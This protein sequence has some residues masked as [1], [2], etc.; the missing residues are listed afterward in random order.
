MLNATF[1]AI[2][3]H[4]DKMSFKKYNKK[5]VFKIT[6]KVAFNLVSEASYGY[7]LSGQKIMKNAQKWSILAFF[8]NLKL[9]VTQCYQTGHFLFYKNWCKM[10]KFENSCATSI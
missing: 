7:I 2:F 10:Q 1:S 6:K 3:E 8:E 5:T 4:Y 9:A